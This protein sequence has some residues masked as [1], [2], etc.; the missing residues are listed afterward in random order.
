MK[1]GTGL[2]ETIDGPDRLKELTADQLEKLAGEIREKIIG[3]ISRNG[4]HLA[5]NLGVVELAI[6]LHR[7]F[8]A[9]E[10]KI[11]WDVGHQCYPHKLLTGRAGEFDTIRRTGGLSGFTRTGESPYDCF[12]AGHAGTAI[13]AAMGFSA[14]ESL[15]GGHD[16]VVAVVGDGALI[17]GISLEAL[18][19]L[20][21]T[22]R[23]LI[24]VLNDNKMSISESIGA[25]PNYLNR[26]ITGRNYNRFKALAKMMVHRLPGG[27]SV[28]GNIQNL[29]ASLKNLFVPGIFFEELGIRYIGPID[30]HKLPELIRTFERIKDF[31]RPVLVHVVTEKGRGCDFASEDPEH[32]HGTGAFHPDTGK[33]DRT[34]GDTFSAAFGRALTELTETDPRVVS[35]TAAMASG[36]GITDEYRQKFP[37][38][39]F[40]VGIAEEHAL[41]FASG[42]AAAGF[43]PVVAIYATF[44]QRALDCIFHDAALQDL[45]VMICLDRA[46]IVEDGPTHHGI[47]DLG[48]LRSIP[49][50]AI[51][52]PRSEAELQAMM[53][54][55][56]RRQTGPVV[57]R[58]PKGASGYSPDDRPAPLEWGRAEIRRQGT[59]LVLWA[60]GRETKTAE[61]TSDI[62][63]EKYGISAAVVNTRFLRPFDRET[64]L[65][66]AEHMPVATLEDHVKE[67]GLASQAAELLAESSAASR[68]RLFP[69]GWSAGEVLPHGKTADIRQSR[70]MTPRQIAE[71]L[72]ESLKTM[73]DH[74]S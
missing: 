16:H 35:V 64:F 74:A 63:K 29:E 62:L 46:G 49:N 27:T 48:F 47:H 39:F 8:H 72:A 32:F 42:L 44:A 34:P 45:P 22:C 31:T 20:R 11:I 57:I 41:V 52:L 1:D 50:L 36:C 19:N 56:H 61:E 23:K 69:F 33:S 43:R 70:G 58:Y 12:G 40:D 14:A 67:G 5:P 18:N 10:D 37:D 7:V 51:L 13:S 71:T 55:A 26:I 66:F 4:G 21:S 17:C 28:I 3:T 65:S 24:V 38:R 25:I 73:S 9:P 15:S 54:E 60:A 6:A 53:E 2:L 68:S 30:G 59:D